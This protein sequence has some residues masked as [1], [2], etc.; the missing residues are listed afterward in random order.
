MAGVDPFLAEYLLGEGRA[1]LLRAFLDEPQR[2]WSLAELEA[3]TALPPSTLRRET[4]ALTFV[5][6]LRR[7][8]RTRAHWLYRLDGCNAS[9]AA[10]RI[11]LPPN[12]P[13]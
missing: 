12:Q 4:T 2:E 3:E 8:Q 6:L 9:V 10:L 13:S 5:G 7:R 1:R 11:L